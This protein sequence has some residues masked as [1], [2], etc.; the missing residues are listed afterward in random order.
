MESS[1]ASLNACSAKLLL[2]VEFCCLFLNGVL[3]L[4]PV[5]MPDDESVCLEIRP[6][7][8][9]LPCTQAFFQSNR[10][11]PPQMSCLIIS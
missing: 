6:S 8:M 1:L 2:G 7:Y 9:D 3:S 4:S 10:A 11:S 5:L